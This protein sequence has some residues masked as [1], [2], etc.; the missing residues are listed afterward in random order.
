MNGI[1]ISDWIVVAV[2]SL[3]TKTKA[4][5]TSRKCRKANGRTIKVPTA[6]LAT[7]LAALDVHAATQTNTHIPARTRSVAI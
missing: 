6:A 2:C 7:T 1:A 4:M 3:V 5:K